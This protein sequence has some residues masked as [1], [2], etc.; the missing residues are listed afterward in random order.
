MVV[1]D[2]DVVDKGMVGGKVEAETPSILHASSGFS[3]GVS[4]YSTNSSI[5]SKT[6]SLG[7]GVQISAKPQKPPPRRISAAATLIVM[8]LRRKSFS[9][10]G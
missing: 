5:L 3:Q 4:I 8:S 1:C 9:F 6:F 2:G 7:E 10:F